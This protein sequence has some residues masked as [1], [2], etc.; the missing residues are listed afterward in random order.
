MV[1]LIKREFLLFL[2]LLITL[3]KGIVWVSVIPLWQG[4]D[5][6]NHFAY[7]QYLVEKNVIFQSYNN[8]VSKE[9][10]LATNL[11]NFNWS[12]VH[13][14]W[15]PN[16]SENRSGINEQKIR[17]IQKNERN[18]F[19]QIGNGLR[20]PPLFYLIGSFFYRLFY[21]SSIIERGYAVRLASVF[22]AVLTVLIAYHLSLNLTKNR[23]FSVSAASIVS[24]HP[25]FTFLGATINTDILVVFLFSLF[26]FLLFRLI[27]K[28]FR[29]REF[30]FSFIIFVLGIFTKIIFLSA[31]ILYPLVLFLSNNS[32]SLPKKKYLNLS[33]IFLFL[34]M[35]SIVLYV[36]KSPGVFTDFFFFLN[37]GVRDCF[38]FGSLVKYLSANFAHYN[39]EVFSWY[40]GIFGW[41][42]VQ[43]PL[44]CYRIL[45]ILFIAS[46]LGIA[47]FLLKVRDKKYPQ[48]KKNITFLLLATL[49]PFLAVVFF[50]WQTFVIR[51]SS[52]GLQG[53]HFLVALIPQMSLFVFG[54]IYLVP[55][56]IKRFALFLLTAFIIVLNL[57]GIL[58]S[59][60]YFYQTNDLNL[61]FLRMN[62]YHPIFL[63]GIV[64]PLIFGF[65]FFSLA[66]FL[67]CYISLTFKAKKE[68][69]V[70]FNLR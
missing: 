11:I 19:S 39:G 40:W 58:V 14:V 5:E 47:L 37:N 17:Q 24:F 3:V 41:L 52:F 64:T 51:G 13:P 53:R 10:I 2:L 4:P 12:S 60:Q 35:G 49:V 50:D 45:K 31:I 16:F 69:D 62:Q 63:K 30:C 29:L 25:S 6:S 48:P 15:R 36:F 9:L 7:I 68:E 22:F 61:M 46:V 38:F 70:F 32:A 20:N 18:E 27:Q 28:G 8:N 34:F 67:L 59:L 56:L 65:F 57:V 21:S 54:I 66:V 26:A 55:S 44:F 43:L 1:A 42:E 33:L 23:F